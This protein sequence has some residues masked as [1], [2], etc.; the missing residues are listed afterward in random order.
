MLVVHSFPCIQPVQWVGNK[1]FLH[2]FD[3]VDGFG[4]T[5]DKDSF[6]FLRGV[7]CDVLAGTLC[8]LVADVLLPLLD[9]MDETF[10]DG[11]LCLGKAGT[12]LSSKYTCQLNKKNI[13]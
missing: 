8:E 1:H 10:G 9:R 4:K 5:V 12:K 6:D 11:I 7:V 3:L 2:L 13:R